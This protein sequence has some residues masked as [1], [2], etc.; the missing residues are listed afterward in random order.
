VAAAE[1]LKRRGLGARFWLVG[2]PDPGN[3]A[4]V[5]EASLSAWRSEGTVE[6]LGHRNDIARVFA[7][8]SI[9]VLPSY[10]GEGVPKV[11]LEAAACGRAVVTT[12]MPGC[13]DAIEA[14]VT[15]LVVPP[16][17]SVALADAIQRLL[18]D[19]ELRARMGCA[20]RQLAEREFSIEYVIAAHLALY[21][22]LMDAAA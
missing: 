18:D 4:S 5:D 17:D 9:V 16:R 1:L 12:D 15:G 19:G 2:D 6:L 8:A 3:P 13:R 21:R 20:G 11:L 22:E 14:G 10:Y 7:Q